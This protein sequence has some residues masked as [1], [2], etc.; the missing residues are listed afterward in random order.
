MFGGDRILRVW[1]FGEA[2]FETNE[3]PEEN[4]DR[5]FNVSEACGY[6]IDKDSKGGI[7]LVGSDNEEVRI[8]FNPALKIMKCQRDDDG[9]FIEPFHEVMLQ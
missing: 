2:E 8:Q 5:L 6:M 1:L 9:R 4:Y 7:M 3:S